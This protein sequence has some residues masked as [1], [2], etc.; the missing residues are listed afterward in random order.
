MEQINNLSYNYGQM[1]IDTNLV[2]NSIRTFAENVIGYSKIVPMVLE[3]LV[4][5]RVYCLLVNT[6]L[7]NHVLI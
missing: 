2:E 4:S 7:L 3:H 6:I 5:S 1:E